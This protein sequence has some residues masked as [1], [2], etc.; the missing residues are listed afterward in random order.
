ML[1]KVA[2][3][4]FC[5]KSSLEE[6]SR[7]VL[8]QPLEARR[9]SASRRF[10]FEN[11]KSKSNNSI[12][13]HNR[14]ECSTWTKETEHSSVSKKSLRTLGR[15]KP[16][17]LNFRV[18]STDAAGSTLFFYLLKSPMREEAILETV[19]EIHTDL[20]SD[21]VKEWFLS[22]GSFRCLA[23]FWGL[24]ISADSDRR[25]VD[26]TAIMADQRRL[27]VS[28]ISFIVLR[29]ASLARSGPKDRLITSVES[30]V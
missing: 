7:T 12:T 25:Q 14:V 10:L 21:L 11:F 3:L 22:I 9:R 18:Q 30:T 4:P 27:Q 28:A 19:N 23:V 17:S 26:R 15:S 13:S 24:I 5:L 20:T 8:R 2:K 6:F 29:L 16:W 1:T